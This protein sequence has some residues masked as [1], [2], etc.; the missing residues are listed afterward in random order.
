MRDART[1][2][3]QDLFERRKQAV[4]LFQKGMS[5][6]EIGEIV[7]VHRNTVGE[8]IKLWQTSG[9]HALKVQEGGRPVGDGRILMPHEEKDIQKCLIDKC[10]DQLKLP[11]SLWTRKA[12]Q[13]LIKE[14]FDIDIAIRTVGKYLHK[15]V[16]TPQ[17]PIKRSY[18][19]NEQH[20]TH[21]L[22]NEYPA[23]A[24]R[25]KQEKAEIHWGDET[26]IRSDNVN[27][28]SYAPKGKTP[29]RRSRGASEQINMISSIT[30][31]GK[32]RFMFYKEKMCSDLLIKFM[33]RLIRSTD[34]KVYLLL[35]NLRVHHSKLVKEWLTEHKAFIEV[36][37]L[38]SYSPDLNPDE[39]LNNDLKANLSQKPAK[40]TKGQWE[41]D[42]K[43]HMRSVQK[44]PEHIKSLFQAESIRYVS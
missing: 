29:V 2:K 44:R 36:Y 41:K 24:A 27:G 26:G 40:K 33:K 42:A 34:K 43:T 31:Q 7:G 21:W 22:N 25:A 20:V 11:F 19:R 5:R 4:K 38:P 39:F 8:W 17:K 9:I 15:W 3:P 37:Y 6:I 18:E 16:F 10:P 28:R 23:I 12:V 13:L 35:D 14:R 30:N 32:V 1:I